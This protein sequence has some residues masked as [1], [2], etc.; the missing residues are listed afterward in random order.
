MAAQTP[1]TGSIHFEEV[2]ALDGLTVIRGGGSARGV[3]S[4]GG[5]GAARPPIG[6]IPVRGP[7]APER[8]I[9]MTVRGVSAARRQSIGPKSRNARTPACAANDHASIVLNGSA[10]CR[11]A[12]MTSVTPV[13]VVSRQSKGIG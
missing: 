6:V 13:M 2:E 12:T 11:R 5:M 9:F 7:G 3:A 8:L 4:G 10:C 1:G